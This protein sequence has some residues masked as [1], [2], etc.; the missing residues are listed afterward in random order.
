[1]YSSE[2]TLLDRKLGRSH[3]ENMR[4]RTEAFEITQTYTHTEYILEA[5]TGKLSEYY[6]RRFIITVQELQMM[7]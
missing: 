2:A 3:T 6:G 7:K 1:M 5:F 4:R